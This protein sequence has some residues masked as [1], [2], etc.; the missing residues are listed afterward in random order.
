MRGSVGQ[1]ER[2]VFHDRPNRFVLRAQLAS[3]RLVIAFLPNP[4]RLRELLLPRARL[5]LEPRD[6]QAAE[7][8]RTSHTVLAV[9]R[10]GAPIYLH[11]HRVNHVARWLLERGRVPGLADASIERAEAPVGHSRFDFLLTEHGKP[12]YLEVKSCTL[13]GNGVAQFPDAVTARG[14]RHVEELAAM[15]R[16]GTPTAV[17]FLIQSLAVDLFMPDYHTDL[18]FA[19]ALLAVR[20]DVRIL[21]VAVGWT[22]RLNLR[23]T[24][25][26]VAVPWDFLDRHVT[27]R[28]AYL[29]LLRLPRKR[30]IQVGRL[31]RL[32]FAAGWYLYVGSAMQGVTQRVA[33]HLRKRKRMHWH[34]DYLRAAAAE[35]EAL[36]IRSADPLECEIAS[37]LAASMDGLTRPGPKGFGCSDCDCATHLFHTPGDPQADARFHALLQ[38]FRMRRP[39][40]PDPLNHVGKRQ[41]PGL[42]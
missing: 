8:G 9:E 14:K 20:K 13:F 37:A 25:R 27:D 4:G 23:R 19:H 41:I 34:I 30:S 16:A 22:E 36:P 32:E 29:L 1:V 12:L 18:A 5:W 28:G 38:R 39:D 10:D 21:P 11:T 33:R 17:L 35:V 6:A 31:G 2:A 40:P 7:A 24:V 15:A 26:P 3:G 42:A